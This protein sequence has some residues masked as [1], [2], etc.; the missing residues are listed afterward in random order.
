MAWHDA[1]A[2][3]T[4][5]RATRI[6][7]L[8]HA[9]TGEWLLVDG[10]H[11]QRVGA[12]EP[13]AADR[14]VDLPGATVL[15]GFVDTHV[16]LTT[17]GLSLVNADVEA[18]RSGK[19][20]LAA[21]RSRC[22]AGGEGPVFLLG[23]DETRWERP[24]V[25]SL[26]DLDAACARPLVI[27]RTDG[28]VAL[29]NHAALEGAG[30]LGLPGAELDVDGTPTGRVTEQAN[31]VVGAWAL[32]TASDHERQDLQLQAAALAASRGVTAVHEMSMPHWDGSRDL[33]VFL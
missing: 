23:Y 5:Y 16:H 4:L 1:R 30:V 27:R 10:R 3:K 19:D 31:E 33:E 12:G 26:A 7:T 32:A 2:V 29:A 22:A 18:A 9:A 15:P 21:A 8:A 28:H 13:P 6:H 14:V 24:E 25:P 11:V 20:L 17:T